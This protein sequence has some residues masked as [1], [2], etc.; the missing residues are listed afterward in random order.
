MDVMFMKEITICYGLTETSPVMTQTRVNDS[1]E[2]RTKTVGRAMPEI[3]VRVVDPET[4][5]PVAPA[6]RARSAAA[7]TTS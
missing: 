4:G 2:Q 1:I 5:E 6:C 3:E 7:G